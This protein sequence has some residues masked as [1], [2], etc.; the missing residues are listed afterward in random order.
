MGKNLS[1][2]I[3]LV[4]TYS[5]IWAANS[6]RKHEK[7]KTKIEQESIEDLKLEVLN[8]KTQMK[9]L[10]HLIRNEGVSKTYP[11]IK[12]VFKN[13]MGERYRL[14]SLNFRIDGEDMY[15]YFRDEEQEI[16][17]EKV[18]IQPFEGALAPGSHTLR[19]KVV[20]QGNDSG[21][22]SYIS[23]YKTKTEG[24]LN[25]ALKKGTT[26]LIEV[27]SFEKGWMLTEFKDRPDLKVLV[28]GNVSENFVKY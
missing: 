28:N 11:K 3:V 8:S 14:H 21:I 23:D 19:V 17:R 12:I 13:K 25:F 18:Q 10:K 22:F 2:A 9:I 15:S 4:F 7:E 27:Q 20:Y 26:T 1:V 6:D 24:Q 16:S 5:T